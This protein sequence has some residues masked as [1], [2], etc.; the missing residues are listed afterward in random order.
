MYVSSGHLSLHQTYHCLPCLVSLH[1]LFLNRILIK[2]FFIADTLF[3]D[4]SFTANSTTD[5]PA[6]IVGMFFVYPSDIS[7]SPQKLQPSSSS[8]I[9]FLFDYLLLGCHNCCYCWLIADYLGNLSSSISR[10]SKTCSSKLDSLL[11]SLPCIS[12]S[13]VPFIS[14]DTNLSCQ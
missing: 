12:S 3:K 6:L 11:S 2:Q 7:S 10:V 8:L 13:S 1:A 14:A 4:T 5:I 9:I